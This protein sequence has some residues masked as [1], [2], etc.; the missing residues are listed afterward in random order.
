MPPT[1][2]HPGE[3]LADAIGAL[4]ITAA[5][6]ARDIQ[7]PPIGVRGILHGARA[8]TADTA[9]RLARY[10]GTSAEFWMQPATALLATPC[11]KGDR[12]GN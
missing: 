11:R 4:G 8:I 2:T 7:V 1:A 6:L 9:L 3:H 10:F 12:H 5:Q